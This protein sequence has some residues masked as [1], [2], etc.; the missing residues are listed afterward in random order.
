M[1]G[2]A[3]LRSAVLSRM[4]ASVRRP[5]ALVAAACLAVAL[6]GIP[7]MASGY[8]GCTYAS[9]VVTL[10]LAADHVV[11]L[12]VVEGHIKFADLTHYEF[13]GP[14]G[15]ATVRNTDRI[16]ITEDQPGN[17]RL[18]FDQ[19]IGRFAPGRT[20]EASGRSEIEVN[21]GTLRDIWIMGRAT[22]EVMTIGELGVNLNGDGDVDLIGSH[23]AEITVFANDGHDVVR[24]TGGAGTGERWRPPSRGYL[25][26]SGGEGDDLLSA[27]GRN[28]HLY[29]DGGFDELRGG[30]GRDSLDGG[31]YSDVIFGG[32]GGDYIIGGSWADVVEA[33]PGDDFIDAYDL[34][35]DGLH[36]GTGFDTA[37]V[38]AVDELTSIE[39]TLPPS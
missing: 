20:L 35:A 34:T 25:S 1:A 39:A 12:L 33:G 37:T 14:C 22:S 11:R 5:R 23:L 13:R 18:Q 31:N 19:Q 36:G 38:D 32:D 3:G 30:S 28:D 21:V 17:S 9:G 27:T 7:A 8:S 15:S 16:R 10:N 2:F 4:E 29:G 6:A 26:A 24:G